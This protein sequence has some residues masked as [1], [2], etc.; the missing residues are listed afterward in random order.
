MFYF[1]FVALQLNTAAFSIV[2]IFVIKAILFFSGRF[3][4]CGISHFFFFS[5]ENIK[6]T[7][8]RLYLVKLANNGFTSAVILIASYY[9]LSA[10]LNL[11]PHYL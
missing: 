2:I 7:K 5:V 11:I 4:Y 1:L 9:L 10:V 3:K 6:N 8:G